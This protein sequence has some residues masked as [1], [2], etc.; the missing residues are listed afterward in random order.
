MVYLS[1]VFI[2]LT[3]IWQYNSL[4]S[5]QEEIHPLDNFCTSRHLHHGNRATPTFDMY[6]SFLSLDLMFDNI[7]S[8]EF[9]WQLCHVA[10]GRKT[11]NVCLSN[12]GLRTH[13]AC[14]MTHLVT[15]LVAQHPSFA[16]SIK[17]SYNLL[18]CHETGIFKY[19]DGITAGSCIWKKQ[20]YFS[21]QCHRNIVLSTVCGP[22][23][24]KGAL[25]FQT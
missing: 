7:K 6:D 8:M 3:T 9:F 22:S 13:N 17:C 18:P 16:L 11:H 14:R 5:P 21:G 23:G 1:L 20:F 25:G 24:G 2:A 12:T 19:H 10:T 15:G 4:F